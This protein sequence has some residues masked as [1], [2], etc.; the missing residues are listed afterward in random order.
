M[1]KLLFLI[2]IIQLLITLGSCKAK[3]L[4]PEQLEQRNELTQ[5]IEKPDFLFIPNNAQPAQGKLIN[6]DRSFS[7]E[8]TKD[9]IEAYLPYYGRAYTAPTDSRDLGIKFTST[10]FEYSS[11]MKKNRTYDIKVEPK[12]IASQYLQGI[13][14]YL[15]VSNSGYGSLSI[16]S[17]S[18]SDT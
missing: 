17:T 16:Q 15:N 1:K 11:V 3:E 13:I 5:K 7:L 8:V 9:T 4:T 14:F 12:D 18:P 10:D 6:L 2:P